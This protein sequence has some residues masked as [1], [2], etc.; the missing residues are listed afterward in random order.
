M[1]EVNEMLLKKSNK[2]TI[3]R[4]EKVVIREIGWKIV[5]TEKKRISQ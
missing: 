2:K 5:I 4:K 3:A 1:E